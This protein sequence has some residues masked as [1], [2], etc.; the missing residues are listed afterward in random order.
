[1][2]EKAVNYTLVASIED[3]GIEVASKKFESISKIS[4][5]DGAR[6]FFRKNGIS[7]TDVVKKVVEQ[8]NFAEWVHYKALV[9]KE[10]TSEIL[11]TPEV[12]VEV[13]KDEEF[14]EEP[15]KGIFDDLQMAAEALW[16]RW[17]DE[18]DYEDWNDYLSTAKMEVEKLPGAT[19]KNLTKKPFVLSFLQGSTE[20][21]IKVTAKK[22]FV[23]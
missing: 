15:I 14:V 7:M 20:H 10:S 17:L 2:T 19:F 6:R 22:V 13:L 12:P 11:A 18:K 9:I 21:Q 8:E 23:K 3:D 1:M 16:N 4:A 5:E